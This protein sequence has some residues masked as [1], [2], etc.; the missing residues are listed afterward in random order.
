[1]HLDGKG[2][3]YPNWPAV[4]KENSRGSRDKEEGKRQGGREG[5]RTMKRDNIDGIDEWL[6]RCF[7]VVQRE[8][9]ENREETRLTTWLDR[10]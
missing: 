7:D 6:D 2:F 5:G 3:R 10:M 1:M 9:T 4:N 8:M